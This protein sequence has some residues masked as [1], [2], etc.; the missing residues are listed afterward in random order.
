MQ[1]DGFRVGENTCP[2]DVTPVSGTII[3]RGQ[4]AQI[5]SGGGPGGW[6][7]GL[8]RGNATLQIMQGGQMINN[9]STGVR[10]APA[11]SGLAQINL[12]GDGSLFGSF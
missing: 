1:V 6:A 7:F 3:V 8:R 11:V 10:V 12:S 2:D 9:Q 5:T 4:G